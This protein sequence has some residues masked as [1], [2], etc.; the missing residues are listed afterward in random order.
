MDILLTPNERDNLYSSNPRYE[1]NFIVWDEALC[2]AQA[3][4]V[5]HWLLEDCT[6]HDTPAYVMG[7]PHVRI[8]CPECLEALRVVGDTD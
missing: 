4:R 1:K 5:Y 7:K 6:E 3:R 2:R 8:D